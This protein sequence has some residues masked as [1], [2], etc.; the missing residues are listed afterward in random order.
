[1]NTDVL[2]AFRVAAGL[3]QNELAKRA[4]VSGPY[5]AML[6][7]GTRQA[8]LTVLYRLA[9]VLGCKPDELLTTEAAAS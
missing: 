5:I 6:E 1:L 9:D 3:S 4:E 2:T 8:S 7:T